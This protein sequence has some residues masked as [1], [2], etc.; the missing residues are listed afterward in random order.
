MSYATV[1]ELQDRLGVPKLT[2]LT[3]LD[4]PSIGLVVPGVAQKALDDA[5]DLIDGY[6]A[7]RY[8]LPLN[9]VPGILRVYCL[10]L[11]YYLLMGS[12]ADE[13]LQAEVKAIRAY[14]A[15]VAD[16]SVALFGATGPIT[17]TDD[18]VVM[19]SAGSK[20]MGREV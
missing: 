11:A 14:L 3:D 18:A 10:T 19:F 6:L 20:V 13:V 5:T 15:K 12:A 9:V 7:G 1:T 4:D 16:G 8:P 17:T 2:Q